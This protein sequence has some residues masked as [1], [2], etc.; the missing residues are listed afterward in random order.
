MPQYRDVSFDTKPTHTR[1]RAF[2]RAGIVLHST[3]GFQSLAWLQ[4]NDPEQEKI[5]SADFLIDRAG[6]CFQLTARGYHSYHVGQ[7]TWHGLNNVANL[8][9]ELLIGI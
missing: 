6:N 9:N 1:R 4:G 7:G 5:A 3:E 8:L 2:G